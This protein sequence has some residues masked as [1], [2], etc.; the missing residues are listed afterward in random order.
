MK[1]KGIVVFFFMVSVSSAF[2]QKDTIWFDA[3]WK[4]VQKDSS[5][6]YRLS[7][8]KEVRFKDFYHFTDYDSLGVKLKTGVSLEERSDKFEGEVVHYHN[9]ERIAERILYKNGFPYGTHKVYYESGKLKSVKTYAYSKLNGPSKVYFEDG[10]LKES[11]AYEDGFR[12]GEWKVYYTN[13]KL[14]EQGQYHKG[15]RVGVWK[16]YYY[17]GTSQE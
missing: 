11:G 10:V 13:R 8:H 6:Y 7:E 3:N 2:S 16:V 12:S 17:N 9:G 1:L 14:K 15:H 4:A 5:S